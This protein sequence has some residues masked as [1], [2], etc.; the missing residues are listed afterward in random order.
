MNLQLISVFFLF[1]TFFGN[2]QTFEHHTL[3][4]T[5]ENN[6]T[7]KLADLNGDNSPELLLQT[8]SEIKQIKIDPAD[9]TNW[10][11]SNVINDLGVSVPGNTFAV[12]DI[13]NDGDIDLIIPDFNHIRVIENDGQ[14]NFSE[15]GRFELDLVYLLRDFF[16]KDMDGDEDLDLV[17]YKQSI[18]SW[19]ENQDDW[20]NPIEHTLAQI[21]SGGRSAYDMN[22][23]GDLNQDI[24]LIDSGQAYW[25]ELENENWTTT[26]IPGIPGDLW[27]FDNFES[28][29]S[30][31]FFGCGLINRYE[32]VNFNTMDTYESIPT[33]GAYY[34]GG[35][36][37]DFN[38]DG[39]PE[40]LVADQF[41]EGTILKV[42]VNP[43]SGELSNEVIL[44]SV[45]LVNHLLTYDYDQD[46]DLDIFYCTIGTEPSVGLLENKLL[47]SNII[48]KRKST[49]TIW[50]SDDQIALKTSADRMTIYS[51][52]GQ[53][54]MKHELNGSDGGIQ[55]ID[56]HQKG[57]YII[58]LVKG[59]VE[60]VIKIML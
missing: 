25:L 48:E 53:L 33:D 16:L 29:G 19:F 17:I 22:L 3:W 26:V 55:K 34:E 12:G 32:V 44:A 45:D 56:F 6:F 10:E 57:A 2:S 59:D 13:D 30:T 14:A 43:V 52:S 47:S 7:L 49:S 15:I 42:D 35:Q 38:N 9:L 21:G 27:S 23:D 50:K 36:F 51:S 41:S 1:Q 24:V 8:S 58:K 20:N 4:N 39:N 28:E 11:R 5:D 54:I 31:T 60:E 46:G 37:V 40:W 18:V